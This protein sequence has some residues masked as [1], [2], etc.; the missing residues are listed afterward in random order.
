MEYHVLLT[1]GTA[2]PVSRRERNIRKRDSAMATLIREGFRVT[3]PPKEVSG[4]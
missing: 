2:V 3:L 1:G 4:V